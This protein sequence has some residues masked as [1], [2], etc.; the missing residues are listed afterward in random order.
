MNAA[1]RIPDDDPIAGCL[2]HGP[3]AS[4]PGCQ[5]E[6]GGQPADG[7]QDDQVE[8]RADTIL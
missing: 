6:R 2:N 3:E 1:I 7:A 5:R 4:S 8:A